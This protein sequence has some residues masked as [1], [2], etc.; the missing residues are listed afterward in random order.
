LRASGALE[1]TNHGIEK[2]LTIVTEFPSDDRQNWGFP[3]HVFRLSTPQVEK[4]S[5]AQDYL[6][7]L[8]PVLV[9][10]ELLDP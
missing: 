5:T 3:R 9:E 8:G 10:L 2:L 6:R 7:R 1:P 4:L